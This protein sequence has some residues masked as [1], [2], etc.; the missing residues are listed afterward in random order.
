MKWERESWRKLYLRE[1]NE[2]LLWP[3][4][5]RSLRDYLLRRADDDG[6]LF[7]STADPAGDLCRALGARD[8]ECDT[9]CDSVRT[10]LAD[11]YLVH[12]TG[13]ELRIRN[14]RDAQERR[15]QAALRKAAQ[16]ERE[17]A[18]RARVTPA[19]QAPV[20]VTIVKR[21][22][23]VGQNLGS[24]PI[25][26]EEKRGD[27]PS[28]PT[29]S[30]Y[31]IARR[32]WAELWGGRYGVTY[33]FAIDAGQHGD[34]R[35]LQRLG[36][37]ALERGAAAESLLRH[38][39]ATY[40]G[41]EAA[42]LATNRHPMRAFERDWNKYGEPDSGLHAV[43]PAERTEDRVPTPEELAKN[44]ARNRQRLIDRAEREAHEREKRARI[45]AELK[46]P[47]QVAGGES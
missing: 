4:L 7:R 23:S 9:V 37:L 1:P 44:A 20:T 33:Q 35:V 3:L 32:V 22:T 36:R 45:E 16:R 40:L 18:A 8:S 39:L 27:P 21:D 11:G 31:D 19:G 30:G 14:L 24:D 10:M 46:K 29:E 47:A 2:Q 5:T 6:V 25:R 43:A 17:R 34:D 13:G 42:W 38:K 41:D 15:S 12:V 26:S 28:P